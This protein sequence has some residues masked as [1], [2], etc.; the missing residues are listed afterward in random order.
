MK[1]HHVTFGG[2]DR[3]RHPIKK[4]YV[5]N[6]VHIRNMVQNYHEYKTNNEIQYIFE[7]NKLSP[8]NESSRN[9]LVS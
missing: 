9:Q 6:H 1:T 3:I 2:H 4:K 8:Q 7:R 5:T